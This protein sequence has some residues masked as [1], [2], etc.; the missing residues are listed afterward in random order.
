MASKCCKSDPPCKDCP[1]R[2]KKKHRLDDPFG[3]TS[4][5]GQ[6]VR[7]AVYFPLT[8]MSIKGQRG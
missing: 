6:T 3:C 8:D 2:K 7:A 4:N 1:K 5:D